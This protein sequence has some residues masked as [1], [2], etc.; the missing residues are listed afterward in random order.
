[1]IWPSGPTIHGCEWSSVNWMRDGHDNA[2]R[3]QET[4][5]G[6]HMHRANWTE[7]QLQAAV[8]RLLTN[9]EM[10]AKLAATA[11]H[12]QSRHGPTKAAGLLDKLAKD[13]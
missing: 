12:M 3:V 4:G 5:H 6:L 7:E 1:M 8:N 9:K 11:A 10:K 2:T 13:V